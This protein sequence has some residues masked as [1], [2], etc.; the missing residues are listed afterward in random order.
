MLSLLTES[1][2]HNTNPAYKIP[3]HSPVLE[4]NKPRSEFT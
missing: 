3:I 4:I 1:Q 2:S